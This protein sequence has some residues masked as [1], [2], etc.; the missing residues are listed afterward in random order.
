MGK[1]SIYG[2]T[3]PFLVECLYEAQLKCSFEAILGGSKVNSF[4]GQ[5]LIALLLAT[6]LQA[7]HVLG[8][9]KCKDWS[10]WRCLCPA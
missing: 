10:Y 8:E 4:T 6:V 3:S 5:Y 9:Y 7:A 1:D 2:W